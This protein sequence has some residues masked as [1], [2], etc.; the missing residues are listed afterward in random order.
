MIAS[1]WNF[2][3]CYIVIKLNKQ[4]RYRK[5]ES[6]TWLFARVNVFLLVFDA[7]NCTAEIKSSNPVFLC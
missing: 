5:T 7:E 3:A 1:N 4:E 6:I 2:M